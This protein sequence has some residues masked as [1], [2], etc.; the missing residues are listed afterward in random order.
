MWKE[1]HGALARA[2]SWLVPHYCVLCGEREGESGTSIPLCARC[3][4]SLVPIGGRRCGRC[5]K[6]LYSEQEFCYACRNNERVCEEV[7]PIFR[8]ADESARLLRSYKSGKRRS[9]APFW[10]ELFA[11]LIDTR[12]PER[13]IVPVPPRPEKLKRKEW[14]QI[15]AIARI[16]ERRGYPVHRLL[17]RKVDTQQKRL[18]REMRKKNAEKAYMVIPSM[19]G[20]VASSILLID[21]VYTTG[22]TIEACANALLI[23][24]AASVAALVIAID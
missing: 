4:Q 13:L 11:G 1:N 2:A 24:G 6:E 12:W 7:Y 23:N 8:Y 3:I 10:A 14:D 22:A 20:E 18:N 19:A 21:D 9:L 5:G 16:L 15:E 17:A